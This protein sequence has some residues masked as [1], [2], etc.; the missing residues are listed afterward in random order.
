MQMSRHIQQQMLSLARLCFAYPV[1][2]DVGLEVGSEYKLLADLRSTEQ[3]PPNSGYRQQPQN[4]KSS[5][6]HVYVGKLKENTS[7]KAVLDHLHDIGV[8]HVSDVIQLQRRMGGQ[9]SFCV[10]VDNSDNEDAM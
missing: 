4:S 9:A 6:Y 2:R 5:D 8:S 1:S 7:K 3:L 10:S